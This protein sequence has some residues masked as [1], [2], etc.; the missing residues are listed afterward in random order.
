MTGRPVTD[1]LKQQIKEY[2]L[3]RPMKRSH[4]AEVFGLS[5]AT[6]GKILHDVPTYTRAKIKSP[7]LIENFFEDI[8]TEEK[9]YFLGLITTDGNVFEPD[10]MGRQASISITLQEED[11][12]LLQ[13]FKDA[14]KTTTAISHDG[15][16]SAMVAIR[17]NI[18]AKDLSKYGVVPR[19][20]FITY[21]P[22]IRED[23][24]PHLIRGIIDGD[25]SVASLQREKHLHGISLCGTHALVEGVLNYLLD[26]GIATSRVSVY[27]YKD[28]QLSQFRISRIED[29]YNVGK[30]LY[31]DAT[32]FMQRKY[33][34]FKD[35]C[36]H[37]H[38][39]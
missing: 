21:L 33:E 27:D 38:L 10:S 18:M 26:K 37:Y 3:S 22:L 20:S 7:D 32:I 16:G 23:L 31:K 35:F 11:E 19:K 36:E 24:M 8:D 13:R 2:Y 39:D 9:A 29:M 12:Y 4:V 1:E 30:W 15:R 5:S 14:T 6:I 25:G 34:A 28:K 17:S